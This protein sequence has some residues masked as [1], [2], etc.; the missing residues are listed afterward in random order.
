MSDFFSTILPVDA[1][2]RQWGGV[3]HGGCSGETSRGREVYEELARD[4]MRSGRTEDAARADA[5]RAVI[6][7][8][9]AMDKSGQSWRVRNG[10]Y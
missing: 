7:A 10:N 5:R 6:E 4:G 3:A 9:S 8:Q 2:V 1:V